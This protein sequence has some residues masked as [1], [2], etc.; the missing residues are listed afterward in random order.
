MEQVLILP[1]CEVFQ[2]TPIEVHRKY[3]QDNDIWGIIES[4]PPAIRKGFEK[5]RKTV[6]HYLTNGYSNLI[7]GQHNFNESFLQNFCHLLMESERLEISFARAGGIKYKFGLEW[8][9]EKILQY[10][11]KYGKNPPSENG[12]FYYL[13]RDCKNNSLKKYRILCWKDLLAISLQNKT[14]YQ[15]NRQNFTGKV[16]VER[17]KKYLQQKYKQTG[18][19]PLSKDVGCKLIAN[20]I[21][22]K[23]WEDFGIT[24]WGD[25]I[26][27]AFGYI[28]GTANLWRG[29]RGLN[30]ATNRIRDYY[31]VHG[32]LPKTSNKMFNNFCG[33]LSQKIWAKDGITTWGDLVFKACGIRPE[34]KRILWAGQAKLDTVKEILLIYYKQHHTLPTC[35]KFPK[36]AQQCSDKTWSEFNIH[37]WNDLLLDIFGKVNK[38]QGKWRGLAGY[39]LAK[40]HLLKIIEQTGRRPKQYDPLC[41]F[42][43]KVICRGY[44]SQFGI[45]SWK[46]LVQKVLEEKNLDNAWAQFDNFNE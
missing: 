27:E 7:R 25:L 42:F 5:L 18:K 37:S 46:D 6:H 9:K 29:G 45:S 23:I 13:K 43:S 39:K 32:K 8:S 26:F 16:G 12:F 31:S 10:Y 11:Q 17:A 34:T 35:E 28:K 1:E 19:I 2:A 41:K 14:F 44:W 4:Y 15:R 20:A 21:R 40:D 24:T 38:Q 33:L 3:W 30:R 22:R 36:I